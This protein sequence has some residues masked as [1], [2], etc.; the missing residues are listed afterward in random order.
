MRCP[1]YVC[2]K[3]GSQGVIAGDDLCLNARH[4]A[5]VALSRVAHQSGE[6]SCE[7]PSHAELLTVLRQGM[8]HVRTLVSSDGLGLTSCDTDSSSRFVTSGDA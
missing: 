5:P 2:G 1:W 8:E 4:E 7:C 6:A 3:H